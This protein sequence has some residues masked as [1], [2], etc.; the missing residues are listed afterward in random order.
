MPASCRDYTAML[1]V[2]A[3]S[4][5]ALERNLAALCAATVLDLS[6]KDETEEGK[7]R[8][9]V[10]RWLQQ[11][12]GWLLI[13]DNADSKPAASAVKALLSHL[14]GGHALITSRLA[15]WAPISKPYRWNCSLPKPLQICCCCGLRRGAAC[16][17]MMSLPRAPWPWNWAI[18][19]GAGTGLSLHRPS[20]HHLRPIPD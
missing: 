12:P 18:S 11:R 6:E 17:R 20:T 8:D 1:L 2:D 13:L 7:Q 9:A 4:A 16:G 10:I 5:E 14:R 19:P 3:D 15:S